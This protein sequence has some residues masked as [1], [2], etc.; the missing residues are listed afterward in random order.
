MT[1]NI[2]FKCLLSG[3][4]VHCQVELAVA[5]RDEYQEVVCADCQ[6]CHFI[7]RK[8]GKLLGEK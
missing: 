3:R 4:T 5:E 8:T 7:N 1:R 6:T 2:L